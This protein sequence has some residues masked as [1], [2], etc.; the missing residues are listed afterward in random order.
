VLFGVLFR[1]HA[2]IAGTKLDPRDALSALGAYGR[3]TRQAVAGT[4]TVGI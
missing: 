2:N 3:V 1:G 4:E